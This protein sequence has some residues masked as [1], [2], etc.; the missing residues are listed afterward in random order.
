M[1]QIF[2][3]CFRHENRIES[4]SNRKNKNFTFRTFW[5]YGVKVVLFFQFAAVIFD[6]V[7]LHTKIAN[8]VTLLLKKFEFI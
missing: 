2:R 4:A 5:A 7:D 3:G 6:W 8:S 1:L